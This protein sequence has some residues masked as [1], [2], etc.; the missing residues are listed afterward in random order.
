[1]VGIRSALSRRPDFKDRDFLASVVG[2][3]RRMAN[4]IEADPIAI[5]AELRR[6]EKRLANLVELA[7]ATGEKALLAKIKET[8]QSI[9]TL[10]Q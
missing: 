7:A 1:M 6:V 5:N 4:E 8:Q 2:E 10:R 3:A 9:D